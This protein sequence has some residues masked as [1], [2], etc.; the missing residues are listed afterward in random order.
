VQL[1]K[2]HAAQLFDV[3]VQGRQ[4]WA[5]GFHGLRER[6]LV[7][8]WNGRA[9][10]VVRSR[11]LGLLVSVDARTANDVWAVGHIG[12]PTATTRPLVEHW[13]GARWHR[14][15]PAVAHLQLGEV[16]AVAADDVWAFGSQFVQDNWHRMTLHW[17]GL[18]WT[19]VPSPDVGIIRYWDGQ[20]WTEVELPTTAETA[21][22]SIEG[23]APLPG[24]EAWF[25]GSIGGFVPF[26]AH[27]VDGQWTYPELPHSHTRERAALR[28]DSTLSDVVALAPDDVVAVGFGI[29]HWDGAKW[30]RSR[31]FLNANLTSIAGTSRTNLWAVGVQAGSAAAGTK[32]IAGRLRC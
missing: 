24:G 3:A 17:N 5:V 28:I 16:E 23:V 21:D 9:W 29:E 12:E 13:D 22:A 15:I 4:A 2:V 10:R 14:A 8:H 26:V 27:V 30:T 11:P 6:V 7:E 18:Q 25:V 1:P 31:I 19:P 32:A 20:K